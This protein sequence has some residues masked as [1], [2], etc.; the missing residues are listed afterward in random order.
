ML[1]L[2]PFAAL[3]AGLWLASASAPAWASPRRDGCAV[4]PADVRA[5]SV[6]GLRID[7]TERRGRDWLRYT[8]R[9][10]DDYFIVETGACER[11]VRRLV[12]ISPEGTDPWSRL[13]SLRRLF[14]LPPAPLDVDQRGEL[15][16]N[17]QLVVTHDRVQIT[18]G[19]KAVGMVSV[20]SLGLAELK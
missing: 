19:Y 6:A 3:A 10:H 1:R 18:Y 8:G 5:A 4:K 13:E 2:F 17:G 12:L 20:I 7:R 14:N 15:L 9:F 16:R 11:N